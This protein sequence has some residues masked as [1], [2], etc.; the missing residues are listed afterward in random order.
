MCGAARGHDALQNQL[1]QAHED[2]NAASEQAMKLSM[3]GHGEAAVQMLLLQG[4]ETLNSR[5]I[6]LAG[7]LLQRHGDT[8]ATREQLAA[9]AARLLQRHCSLG[10]RLP[11][12]DR[13]R[14]AGALALNF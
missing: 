1:R 14:E 4:G 12:T 9:Q 3:A 11:L 7:K 2:I 8:I 5:L 13:G 10:T 6:D